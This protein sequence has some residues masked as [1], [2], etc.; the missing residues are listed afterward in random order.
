MNAIESVGEALLDCVLR[1]DKQRWDIL[2]HV[3]DLRL[4]DCWVAAGFVRNAIWDH[5]HGQ[6]LPVQQDDVDVIWFDSARVDGRIDQCLE[7]QLA[8][9]NASIKWSIKNQARMHIRNGDPPYISSTDSMRFWPETATAIAVRLDDTDK[10][11]LAAPY[12]LDDLISL[13]VRPTPFFVDAKLSIHLE[14][15][16]DKRWAIRWPKLNIMH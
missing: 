13:I 4:P 10:L 9:V 8:H 15:V 12:G 14:R 5:L 11:A 16:R 2:C 6:A 1:A 7:E 3:R